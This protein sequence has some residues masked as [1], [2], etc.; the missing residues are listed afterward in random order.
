MQN[1]EFQVL[2]VGQYCIKQLNKLKICS[3]LQNIA[4]EAVNL[5]LRRM[6]SKSKALKS[7][8]DFPESQKADW[9][10]KENHVI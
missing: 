10:T 7:R 5:L 8:N 4:L 9:N 2:E 1:F 3:S 6:Q